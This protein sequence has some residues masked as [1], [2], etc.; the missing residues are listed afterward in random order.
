MRWVCLIFPWEE[1]KRK[2]TISLKQYAIILPSPEMEALSGDSYDHFK[3]N[4]S[5]FSLNLISPL[6]KFIGSLFCF[7][8]RMQ[9]HSGRYINF[10]ASIQVIRAVSRKSMSVP[11]YR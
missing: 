11:F 1:M 5:E 2:T 8:I 9:Q 3:T 10:Y 6:N 4:Q 7:S